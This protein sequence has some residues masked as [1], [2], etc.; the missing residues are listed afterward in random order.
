MTLLHSNRAMYLTAFALGALVAFFLQ[1]SAR[2]A[3]PAAPAEPAA[4]AQIVAE[5]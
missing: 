2:G 1:P 5:P 4:R 3:E